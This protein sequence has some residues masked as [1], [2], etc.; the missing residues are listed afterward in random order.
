M[1]FITIPTKT[2][3]VVAKF[4]G[5]FFLSKYCQKKANFEGKFASNFL[6]KQ[7]LTYFCFQGEICPEIQAR[8]T[9][10]LEVRYGG[11]Y[12]A[13]RAAAVIQRSWRDYNLRT[14]FSRVLDLAKSVERMGGKRQSLFVEEELDLAEVEMNV[15]SGDV[16]NLSPAARH[17]HRRKGRRS[18]GVSRSSSLK[19]N[20]RRSGSWSGGFQPI[21]KPYQCSD[22][23]Q[24][25]DSR[26][27]TAADLQNKM[28]AARE[29]PIPPPSPSAS[30]VPP[31]PPLRG[32]DF[33][34]DHEPV[35]LA[36]DSLYC[37]VR[38]P[39]RL[40]PRP[41]QRTVSFLGDA[42]TPPPQVHHP[43]SISDSTLPRPVLE[44]TPHSR[45]NSSPHPS[46]SLELRR[47]AG[48]S[49]SHKTEKRSPLPPP[50]YIPPPNIREEPLPPPPAELVCGDRPPCD[51]VSSIDSGFR[52]SCSE[53]TSSTE[54]ESIPTS[55]HQAPVFSEVPE[56][57]YSYWVSS[58]NYL[59]SPETA[60]FYRSTVPQVQSSYE[61]PAP[62]HTPNCCCDKPK[63]YERYED[64][65]RTAGGE[66][67]YQTGGGVSAN[68]T[69]SKKTVRIQLPEEEAV[70]TA[71]NGETIRRRNYRVGLNLFNANPERGINY[72]AKKD[73]I[74]LNPAAVARFLIGRKGLSKKMVG[75]YICNLQ[76][77]FSMAVLQCMVYDMDFSGLH[78]DIALRQLLMEIHIPGEAQKIEKL[79]EVFARR[80]IECNQMFVAGFKAPDTIFILSYAMVLLNTD[81]HNSSIKP[82]KKMRQ[83]DFLRN[84]RGI[85]SGA[86]VDQDM[87][88]GIYDRIK[89]AEFKEGSDHVSQ[90]SKVQDTITGSKR[91]KINATW[92]RLVC[93]CRVT[94]V[95][96]MQK[97]EK[98]DS[99]QRG[100][101]LFNDLLV[102]TKSEKVRKKQVH[103]YRAS[104]SLAGLR[105]TM[106]R[107]QHHQFGVQLQERHTGR[108]AATF[109]C[110]SYNDQQRFVGDL[111]ESISEVEEMDRARLFIA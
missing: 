57:P 16:I 18:G 71:E 79:V 33:Y 93:F 32:E 17:I 110:R 58:P 9:E 108:L 65:Y 67:L 92:R 54:T 41:P 13:H 101:F 72:L 64:L 85:D 35:Y 74:E 96:D 3:L 89:A 38:R 21:D 53:S 98:K 44:S 28:N 105:V 29:S 80:Y 100:I 83:E 97:K 46:N 102:V 82:E 69:K 43:I 40:P 39:R 68:Q 81:L 26:P 76:K 59:T 2:F 91:P 106:F 87:L 23:P 5:G 15:D 75:E 10:V 34:P 49:S 14:K 86:N 61:P 47:R 25:S 77:P 22:I 19:D 107:T 84:L 37:S 45:S 7:I 90:V 111:E 50:P 88:K 30:P 42:A 6:V 104:V 109:A 94:E 52:S 62:C 1:Y 78:L 8:Q 103:Q 70:S 51:S 24:Y 63:V 11:R 56:D 60:N 12:T 73:F 95:A 48:S 31:C 20:H 99:H 66:P 36:R 55:P 4:R 27:H